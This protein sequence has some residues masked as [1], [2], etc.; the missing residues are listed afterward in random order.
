MQTT[1]QSLGYNLTRGEIKNA[2]GQ[3]VS[4]R[5][6]DCSDKNVTSDFHATDKIKSVPC[7][8]YSVRILSVPPK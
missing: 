8:D 1:L 2:T 5:S 3:G 4:I 7:D 6:T